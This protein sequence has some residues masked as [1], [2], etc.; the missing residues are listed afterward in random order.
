[1]IFCRENRGRC[2]VGLQI[3]LLASIF[4][5]HVQAQTVVAPAIDSSGKKMD[6]KLMPKPAG[7]ASAPAE[8][9]K[10]VL[11]VSTNATATTA[12]PAPATSAVLAKAPTTLAPV[13]LMPLAEATP[14]PLRREDA[15]V[16]TPA[17]PVKNTPPVEAKKA[18]YE[19]FVL[20]WI[21]VRHPEIT[22][23]PFQSS[24]ALLGS[25]LQNLPKAA[26]DAAYVS[27]AISLKPMTA[28]TASLVQDWEVRFRDVSVRRLL[29]R[30]A[31]DAQYQLIWESSRDFPVEMEVVI[32]GDFRDGVGAVMESLSQT[33]Y[34]VQA[35]INSA[36]RQVRV[37]RYLKGQAR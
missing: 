2:L 24:Q 6:L 29:Q 16:S 35:L 25:V 4:T 8:Q 28:S 3:S 14:P 20:D 9:G 26:S 33:D 31:L 22:S 23:K 27:S 13:V 5:V 36:L 19:S 32:H 37:V 21:D 15:P 30:W 11:P 7:A 17:V 18:V 34:P 1:M 12:A 10:Q